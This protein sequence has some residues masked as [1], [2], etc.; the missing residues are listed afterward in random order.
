MPHAAK[1]TKGK[2]IAARLLV[3][4]RSL[5]CRSAFFKKYA[6]AIVHTP[7]ELTPK[8]YTWLFTMHWSLGAQANV[9]SG[10]HHANERIRSEMPTHV[11]IR[12]MNI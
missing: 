2:R 5:V 7:V 10:K 4:S 1:W 9:S 12:R 8:L 6:K 3:V 11:R